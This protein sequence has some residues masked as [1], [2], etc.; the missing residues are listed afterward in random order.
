[1][2]RLAKYACVYKVEYYDD[3]E[4]TNKIE[5]G[6]IYADNFTHATHI[7]ED[8]IY[9]NDLINILHMELFETTFTFDNSDFEKILH[10]MKEREGLI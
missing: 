3:S 2:D 1:M 8:E 9:G 4:Q 6:L 5:G 10:M 7:L